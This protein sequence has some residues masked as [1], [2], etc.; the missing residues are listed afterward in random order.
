MIRKCIL[1][2][3][4]A[5]A[6][7][8][9]SCKKH[10]IAGTASANKAPE[11]FTIVDTIIRVGEERLNAEVQIRWWG[12]DADGFISGFEFTFDSVLDASTS[13]T[14]T[15]RYDSVFLLPPPPGKD[16]IDFVFSVRAVD[17]TDAR[18]LTPARLIYPIKNTP[19]TVVFI[20][21]A[22]NPINT[23]PALRFYWEATDIDG[24]GSIDRFELVWNDTT[25]PVYVM[26]L[27]A[28]S[29]ILRATD[30][31][32]ATPDCEVFLNNATSP[33]PELMSG[34][35]LNDTNRL[36][37]RAIDN[38]AASSPFVSSY[39]MYVRMV[40]SDVLLVN[41][42]TS[43][44]STVE[45]FYAQSLIAQGILSFDTIQIFEKVL[46]D[47]TQQ[48]PD[49]LSQSMIFDFF[50]TLIWFGNNAEKSLSLAQK[51]TISF[52]GQGGKMLMAV[53]VSSS[54][55]EQSQFLDFTPIATLVDPV[56]TTLIL[57]DTSRLAPQV[58]GWPQLE[59]TGFV[60]VVKPM[61]LAIGS[62]ALYSSHLLAR[63]DSTLQISNWTGNAAVIGRRLN[64][65]MS[66]FIISTL[67]LQ[68]LNGNGNI[69]SLFQ[70]VYK[71]EFGL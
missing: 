36:Y 66:N 50:E 24:S 71:D 41:A 51:T 16:S 29:A 62:D 5:G 35:R 57:T 31:R 69:D 44:G 25:S 65:G 70:K 20:P 39:P 12:D 53:Y 8:A 3:L 42:Y 38:S 27:E 33:E 18:D 26:P 47:L 43:G 23:F 58:S 34:L 61:N 68:T 9:E 55:D 60:G 32:N 54:F 22:Q 45:D 56:D 48:S 15:S 4:S 59:S 14:F 7:L 64:G 17:N 30:P 63:D 21:G 49:N 52:F 6:L 1:I 46:G 67:E 13:W 40:N 11:T 19:P 10:Q 28:T 37:I 2:G